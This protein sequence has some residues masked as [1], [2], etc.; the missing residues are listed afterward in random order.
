M[1]HDG[2]TDE[3]GDYVADSHKVRCHISK[4]NGHCQTIT[5]VAHLIRNHHICLYNRREAYTIKQLLSIG[6]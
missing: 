4:Y 2:Q 1:V 3:N 5:E 6:C